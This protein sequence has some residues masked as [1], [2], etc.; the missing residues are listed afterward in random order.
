MNASSI[1]LERAAKLALKL[2]I[3]HF[4]QREMHSTSERLKA[5]GDIYELPFALSVLERNKEK[6]TAQPAIKVVRQLSALLR[7]RVATAELS[8]V[9]KKA[10]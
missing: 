10:A 9:S 3:S 1:Q 8:I 4:E 6:L 7:L 5:D 2:T